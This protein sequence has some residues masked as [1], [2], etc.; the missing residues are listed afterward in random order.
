MEI[1]RRRYLDALRQFL[2]A[3]VITVVTGLRRAGKSVLL[4]QFAESLR[5]ERQVVYV[6]KESL[7]FD[8][9]RTARD[10]VDFVEAN[11]RRSEPRVVVVDEI[12]QIAEWE[13]AAASLN[14]EPR[15]EV[16]GG[17]S[18]AALLSSE[19][20]TRI[21]GRYA[22]VQV[23]PLS[24]GEFTELYRERADAALDDE[25]VFRLYLRTGGLP[26]LLHT[27]LSDRVLDRMLA[28]AVS[29]IAIRDVIGRHGIR[30]VALLE[31]VLRFA[32]DVVGSPVSAKRIADYLKS[33]RRATSVDTVL[34]YLSF[35]GDAFLLAPTPRFDV[36]GKRL[37]QVNPKYYLG[38]VGLRREV[39]GYREDDVGAVLENLVYL[40]LRRRGF[41]VTAGAAD[42]DFVA[43]RPRERW[44]V[45]L[46]PAR[47]RMSPDPRP[48]PK[49]APVDDF[50][51]GAPLPTPDR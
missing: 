34:N 36:R 28:D 8:G 16:V 4:R 10:L 17:G 1:Q 43:S 13:R 18:N 2:D 44:F 11:A 49:G 50:L 32:A 23:F 30:D 27:D 46:D 9:V 33:Q 15:T 22:T 31:S 25:G 51:R 6:D 29:T 12:Q 3:P 24:L 47:I 40:E 41:H 5:D 37:L 45:R 38:D 19:L 21:A 26:G 48:Q 39:L 35:L 42:V 20:A 7:D 14:A